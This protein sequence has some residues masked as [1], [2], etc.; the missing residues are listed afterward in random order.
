MRLTLPIQEREAIPVRAIP[1]LTGW[2]LSPDK[3][4]TVFAHRDAMKAYAKVVTY[5]FEKGKVFPMLA[6]EWD[7]HLHE[8]R[9]FDDQ[10]S[11]MEAQDGARRY[12]EWRRKS[13]GK[14][15][16]GV[17]VWRDEFEA[18]FSLDQSPIYRPTDEERLGDRELNYEVRLPVTRQKLVFAGFSPLVTWV[19]ERV[20]KPVS[21]EDRVA[22]NEMGAPEVTSD[23]PRRDFWRSETLTEEERRT[24]WDSIDWQEHRGIV[25]E[26]VTHFKNYARAGRALGISRPRVTELY[27][28]NKSKT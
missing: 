14:L 3:V 7:G 1:L 25:K 6:K 13:L 24:I 23:D 9:E 5:C 19:S 21:A 4:A 11:R 15:P 17:F 2:T 12:T 27:K 20:S 8:L 10:L 26:A 18:A 28:E 22:G 16:A